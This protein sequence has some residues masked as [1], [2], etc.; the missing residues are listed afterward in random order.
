MNAGNFVIEK[1]VT[2]L[3]GE[4]NTDAVHHRPIIFASL[5]RAQKF[6]RKARA[7]REFRDAFESAH[8][9]NRHDAGNDRNVDA[10]K[11][12]T[13]AKIKKVTVIEK[14]LGHD[15]IGAGIHFRFQM[16]HFDQAIRS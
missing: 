4:V 11:R 7:A 13:L 8:G 3:Q 5:E 2:L 12:A 10:G 1:I 15:V 14:E 9:G 16:I 6:R